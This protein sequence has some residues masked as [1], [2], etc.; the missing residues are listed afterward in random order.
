MD[1]NEKIL[2]K[3][4][5]IEKRLENLEKDVYWLK[6]FKEKFEANLLENKVFQETK[7]IESIPVKGINNQE[8]KNIELSP[9][10]EARINVIKDKALPTEEKSKYQEAKVHTISPKEAESKKTNFEM[11]F[12]GK[13]INRIGIAALILAVA[14]FLKYTFDNNLIGP[15]GRIFIGVLIGVSMLVSGDLLFKKYRLP[16]EGLLG[17][18]TAILSFTLFAA[19]SFYS[20]INHNIAIVLFIL[21]VL[22]SSFLAIKNDTVALMHISTIAGFL[23]PFLFSTGEAND[24]FFLSYLIILNLGIVIISYYKNWKSL[25]YVAFFASHLCLFIWLAGRYQDMGDAKFIIGF[26][27]TTIIYLEFLTVSILMN[28][29]LNNKRFYTGFDF[30][31]LFFNAI[32]FYF[33]GCYMINS[34]SDINFLGIFTIIMAILY[35]VIFYVLKRVPETKE[36]FL[37]SLLLVALIFITIAI[38]VQLDGIVVSL[39]W[40]IETLVLAYLYTK[41]GYKKINIAYYILIGI[42]SYFI[43]W[44]YYNYLIGFYI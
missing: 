41:T 28:L 36:N 18:G 24:I 21:I 6:V 8:T 10:K 13:W 26:I 32:I 4:S 9:V 34:I 25:F 16:S 38:P 30:F 20:L 14:F 22:A 11:E 29:D 33:E 39:A 27:P 31:L 44:T 37:V 7:N 19:F 15:Q 3:L 17:G 12:G 2:E 40:A 5:L 23:T 42:T 1:N 35:L 43:F